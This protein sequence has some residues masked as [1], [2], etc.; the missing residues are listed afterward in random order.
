MAGFVKGSLAWKQRMLG[1]YVIGMHAYRGKIDD[2]D[3][4]V[5]YKRFE[6]DMTKLVA[7]YLLGDDSVETCDHLKERI[8]EEK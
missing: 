4:D 8:R 6:Q 7:Y 5:D 1:A 2:P 3:R